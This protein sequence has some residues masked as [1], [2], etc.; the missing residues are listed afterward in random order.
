MKFK[1]LCTVKNISQKDMAYLGIE[2]KKGWKSLNKDL[3]ITEEQA[4]HIL[5]KVLCSKYLSKEKKDKLRS[6]GY[7]LPSDGG[8]LLYLMEGG[9]KRKIGISKDPDK[10]VK[11]LNTG[12]GD[13]IKLL[14]TWKTEDCVKYVEGYLHKV[15][16]EYRTNG[17]W[18]RDVVTIQGVE[19]HIPCGYSRIELSPTLDVVNKVTPPKVKLSKNKVIHY[20]KIK[21][22]TEKAILIDYFNN[23][24]WIAKSTIVSHDIDSRL[25]TVKQFVNIPKLL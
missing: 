13:K 14:A 15:F 2:C 21:Y 3:E 10:R 9:N 5:C 25:I 16:K 20:M 17:E 22:E 4:K 7:I 11:E 24:V 23:D 8:Q 18:F 12:S 6:F 1:E 19:D